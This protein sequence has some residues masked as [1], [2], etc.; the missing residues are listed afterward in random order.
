MARAGHG[1]FADGHG[2]RS[3]VGQHGGILRL[4]SE[5]I[6]RAHGGFGRSGPGVSDKLT[7][8]LDGLGLGV[9]GDEL[10]RYQHEECVVYLRD[11]LLR[12]IIDAVQYPSDAGD[13]VLRDIAATDSIHDKLERIRAIIAS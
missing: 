11:G 9:L 10:P 7:R 5:D 4:T 6:R 3:A 8:W 13:Q 12:E 2:L 1:R